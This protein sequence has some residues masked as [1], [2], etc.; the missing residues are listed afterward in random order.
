MQLTQ[1]LEALLD[2]DLEPPVDEYRGIYQ[3]WDPEFVW[4][5][6]QLELEEAGYRLRPR[7]HRDWKPSWLPGE[8]LAGQP[9]DDCEDSLSICSLYWA[10]IDAIRVKDGQKVVLK[11]TFNYTKEQEILQTFSEPPFR[12]SPQNHCVP[13]LDT[14][15]FPGKRFRIVVLPYLI[16][17]HGRLHCMREVIEFMRQ[18]LQGLKFMHDQNIAHRDISRLN[19]MMTGSHVIPSENHFSSYLPVYSLESG[20]LVP[21]KPKQHLCQVS[22]LRYFFIDFGLLDDYPDGQERARTTG[23]VGQIKVTP[24][25][26]DDVPYN[27]FKSDIM[28][29]GAVFKK[30]ECKCFPDLHDFDVLMDRMTE[31]KWEDRPGANEALELFEGIVSS[32]P[33]ERQTALV[34]RRG[35]QRKTELVPRV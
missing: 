12:N 10:A 27:P 24:E 34:P 25:L 31:T 33:A 21:C 18:T 20:L 11:I 6:L 2:L 14:I 23:I 35:R 15:E 17:V 29:L 16:S 13:V 8:R 22:Q 19:I 28:Q 4:V 5:N 3:R 7:Y 32:M 1:D 9:L 30:F 26:S